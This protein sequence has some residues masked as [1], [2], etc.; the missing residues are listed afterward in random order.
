VARYIDR[1]KYDWW[2][3]VWRLAVFA[4]I[5]AVA[6]LWVYPARGVFWAFALVLFAAWLFVSLM[7]RR[8]G[9]RCAS[10]GKVFQVPTTINFITPSHMAKN[11]DGTYYSYKVLPCPH[12]GKKTQ[13]KLVKRAEARGAGSGRVL[14]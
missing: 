2:S 12:C 9:Y 7:A 6:I 13:A 14:K 4:G 1:D 5:V 11:K 3:P 8:S 10:C